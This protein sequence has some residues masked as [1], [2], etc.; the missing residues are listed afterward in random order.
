MTLGELITALE[1]APADKV[2]PLGFASPHSYRGFYEQLAFEPKVRVP[3]GEML[4]AARSALGRTYEG[5]KGGDFT[6]T[7]YT[8]CWLAVEGHGDGESI[9]PIL[10]TLMLAASPGDH[11]L[12]SKL[13]TFVPE[14]PQDRSRA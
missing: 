1:A 4:A 10:L 7:D 11:E 6:M 13:E 9:G 3:V 14:W 5:W 8:D 2:L 12:A